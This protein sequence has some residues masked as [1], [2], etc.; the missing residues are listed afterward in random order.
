MNDWCSFAIVEVVLYPLCL[1]PETSLLLRCRLIL[2]QHKEGS[3]KVPTEL[4]TAY[5]VICSKGGGFGLHLYLSNL[6]GKQVRGFFLSFFLCL[7]N[8]LQYIYLRGAGGT[9]ADA[10]VNNKIRRNARS[11]AGCRRFHLHDRRECIMALQGPSFCHK[12]NSKV[13]K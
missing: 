11:N 10:E 3:Q 9:G 13:G 5:A 1:D 8:W 7:L 2:L 4:R 6:E 12:C